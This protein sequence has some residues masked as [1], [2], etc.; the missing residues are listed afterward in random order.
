MDLGFAGKTVAVMA[1]SE[2]L[3]RAAAEAFVKEGAAVAVCARRKAKLDETVAALR[4]LRSGARVEGVVADVA[5]P[6]DVASFI[7][8]AEELGGGRL[9]ALVTNHGGPPPTYFHEIDDAA[10]HRNVDL[11]LLSHVRAV[12]A[13]LPALLKARGAV[14][15]ITSSTVKQPI[16]QIILSN[17]LRMAVVGLYKTLALEYG[18]KGLRFNCVCPGSMET[19]RI[20]DLV[21]VQAKERGT[22][23]AEEKAARARDIP[24][25]RL[26]EP[27]ELGEVIAFLASDRA[28][29]VTGTTVSVDGGV[30]RW[31]YG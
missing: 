28:S 1:A 15:A 24:L 10:W 11:I 13:A 7:R 19:A 30:V 25:G 14:V 17:S 12:R 16:P 26:G 8:A 18:A 4:K 23:L 22:S 31:V 21:E 2:G 20:L 27:R 9:D 6:K 29:Y 5:E 3:G